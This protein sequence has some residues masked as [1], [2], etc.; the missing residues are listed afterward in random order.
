MSV[1]DGL[2]HKGKLN[3]EAQSPKEASTKGTS[4]PKHEGMIK[5]TVRKGGC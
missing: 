2:S 3:P 5:R 1:K 4:R